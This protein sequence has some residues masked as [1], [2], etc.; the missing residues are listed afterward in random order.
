MYSRLGRALAVFAIA[1]LVGA[2]APAWAQMEQARLLGTVTDAQGAVLPGVTVTVT[3]PALIGAQTTVTEANGKYLLPALPAGTYTVVFELAGFSTFKREGITLPIGKTLTVDAQMQ[4]ASLQETVT[5]S[6]ESPI[7]DTTTTRVSTEFSGEKLVGIPTSTDLWATL[8]QA[9]G[10][11][12]RGFDVGGSHKSQQ[13]NYESFGIRGQN[14]I[15]NEG[16]DTTEGNAAAGW[17]PDYFVND[18]ISISAAG[19][20]VEMNT[21]GSAVVQTTKS[22]G[23]QFKGLENISYE[24]GSFVGNNID[25][26]TADRG[27]TG[28]PNL[29][30][31]EGHA[32]LGGPVKRD[33]VW[34]YAAYNHFKINKAISGVDQNIATD[35]GIFDDVTFKGTAKLSSR[36]TVIGYYSWGRKQKPSRGLSASVSPEAV[37]AQDS[38]SWLYKGQW[39]RVWTNRLFVD[40]QVGLFGYGWPM[41][42]KVDFH[43]NPPRIDTATNYQTGAGWAVGT[44][45]GPFNADRSKPQ[46]YAKATYFVP[47]KMGSHDLKLGFEWQ[48]DRSVFTN[49]GNSGPIYYLDK[50][51]AVDEVRLTDFNTFDSFGSTWTGNDDRN[52]R[53]VIY[54]QDRWSPMDRATITLGM[55]YE[56]QRP[57]YE[58]SIRKPILTEVFQDLTTPAK[59]LLVRNTVSPRLGLS[60]NLTPK[61]DTVLK[62]FWGRFYFNFADRLS[63]V[64]PGGTNY[65]QYKFLDVNGNRIYDGP[66]EL[67]TLVSSA[68]GTSTTLDPNLK[69]PY[70]DEIDLSVERQFW[71]ESSFRVAY[72][73]KMTRNDFTTYNVLREGQFT[74]PTT[75]NVTIRQYGDPNTTVQQFT[76]MDIPASL[77]GQVQNVV[78]NI[79][80]GGASNYDT[81][82]FAFKKRF[83]SGL[84]LDSSF[85][86]QWR[87]ELRSTGA[88]TSPLN[89]D[90]LGVGYAQNQSV[91]QQVSN[92]QKSTNWQARLMGRYAFKYD[93]AVAANLRAQSGFPYT[94]VISASL[95]NAGTQ[96]FLLEDINSNRSDTTTIL[97]LRFEKVFTFGST[98]LTAMADVFNLLNS[99]A[100]TNFFLSNGANYNKIIATLD[101]RTAQ[102]A[103]RFQF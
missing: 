30:F 74:V 64:N 5:V 101:P 7:V 34:F 35:L 98:R 86:Y 99:N 33:K 47:D 27:F 24:P 52:M 18:E 25:T 11:R 10:V 83:G 23:N 71:G 36:D 4:L 92:R 63:N 82:Q 20:D 80:G 96:T 87:N 97:D 21:P 6:G 48:D 60:Y 31:W 42:P 69:T 29:I 51:G 3:S 26:A 37:L 15:V 45:G 100:V 102:I 72:V 46:M 57:H 28:Q 16:V 54:A 77:K 65:K 1:A 39:Q 62:A 88:T 12:M 13:S 49:N 58:A 93:F 89:S 95:P 32:E 43:A 79:P 73:R 68:G 38:A 56:R 91:Y 41:A 59:T 70:A 81:L 61:G 103:L 8:G 50:A 22:G 67:G 14:R 55:R 40:A 2:A 19:G 85:D 94:R 75:V 90:P 44:S 84:F 9:P 76:L 66:Q 17:Y 78:T 53:H